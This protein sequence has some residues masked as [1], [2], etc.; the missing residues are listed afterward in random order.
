MIHPT[1][2]GLREIQDLDL[3]LRGLRGERDALPREVARREAE[4]SRLRKE[5]EGLREGHL[6]TLARV[7]ELENDTRDRRDRI[8]KLEIQSNMVK[9][10]A[11]LL[12]LQHQVA[13]LR[14]EISRLEDE[15]IG[16]LDRIEEL[17]TGER[18]AKE[19]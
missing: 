4:V 11:E 16:L 8:A 18:R 19:R 7:K 1:V 14:E 10:T 3:E 17:S 15:G 2:Q 13:T 9:H 5:I 6:R 12:A